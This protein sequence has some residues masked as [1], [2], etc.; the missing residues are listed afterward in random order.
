MILLVHMPGDWFQGLTDHVLPS[1]HVHNRD[2]DWDMDFYANK[3]IPTHRG[4]I[5]YSTSCN[6]CKLNKFTTARAEDGYYSMTLH[7]TMHNYLHT[8]NLTKILTKKCYCGI[9]LLV[10]FTTK[11][12][13]LTYQYYQRDIVGWPL[14]RENFPKLTVDLYLT[15]IAPHGVVKCHS[16]DYC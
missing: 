9:M 5:R 2:V 12:W 3:Y 10:D 7:C 11:S 13:S 14:T 15:Q 6:Y 8:D 4:L 16:L 1:Y